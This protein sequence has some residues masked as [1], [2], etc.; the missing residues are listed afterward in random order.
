[1][2]LAQRIEDVLTVLYDYEYIDLDKF[3]N[4]NENKESLAL[5][6]SVLYKEKIDKKESNI[7]QELYDNIDNFIKFETNNNSNIGDF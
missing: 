1:M 6:N 5:L 4:A 2:N 3:Y 7:L